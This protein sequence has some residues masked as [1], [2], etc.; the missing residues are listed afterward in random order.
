VPKGQAAAL[1]GTGQPPRCGGNDV[2]GLGE[3]RN[4]DALVRDR[5]K[6]GRG[7]IVYL[8]LS[9]DFPLGDSLEVFICRE[10]AE[11]FIEEVRDDEPQLASYLRVE[12]RELQAGGLN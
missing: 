10:D 11:R 7:R 9:P 2:F 8:A 12:E 4:F 6:F 5:M 3:T 1:L